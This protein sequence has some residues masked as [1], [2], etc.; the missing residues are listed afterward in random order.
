[1]ASCS[2]T[3]LMSYFHLHIHAHHAR[4]NN[5]SFTN[6]KIVLIQTHTHR[7][8]NG[9][10]HGAVVCPTLWTEICLFFEL[11]SAACGTCLT[12]GKTARWEWMALYLWSDSWQCS[13]IKSLD[14]RDWCFCF[15]FPFCTKKRPDVTTAAE[16]S[17]DISELPYVSLRALH[18]SSGLS[19][20]SGVVMEFLKLRNGGGGIFLTK[21]GT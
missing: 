6:N 1:M 9:G 3:S 13:S 20:I 19:L 5:K 15:S 4:I 17:C 16:Q 2:Q 8:T 18:S 14:N 11:Q 12:P 10:A 21:R 7:N